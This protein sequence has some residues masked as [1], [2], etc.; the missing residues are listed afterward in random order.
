M[1]HPPATG[2]IL[3]TPHLPTAGKYGP[4]GLLLSHIC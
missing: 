2:H 4:P 1:G 3:L